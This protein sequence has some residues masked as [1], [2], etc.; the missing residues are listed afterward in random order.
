MEI[1]SNES[2]TYMIIIIWLIGS[3]II[4][5]II[6]YWSKQEK[7]ALITDIKTYV[8]LIKVN[9]EIEDELEK[10]ISNYKSY[11]EDLKKAYY[12]SDNNFKL[13]ETLYMNLLKDIVEG[14]II[15]TEEK[16]KQLEKKLEEA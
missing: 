1:I 12:D 6:L 8:A 13:Q 4:I 2:I 7:S 14:K 16:Y 15:F 9:K 5:G 10:Q 11:V 3:C